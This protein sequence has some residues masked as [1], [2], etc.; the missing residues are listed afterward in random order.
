MRIALIS[1]LH[2]S[3]DAP[4]VLRGTLSL[5]GRSVALRQ[6]EFAIALGCERILCL[7]P[8]D[9]NECSR[10]AKSV[11]ER[12]AKLRIMSEAHQIVGHVHADDELLVLADGLLPEALEPFDC[13]DEGAGVLTL[14]ADKGIPA[15]FERIDGSKAW[16]GAMM[17]PGHLAERLME[18]P[19]DVDPQPALLR[20]G[21]QAQIREQALSNE[22]LSEGRWL[23]LK[24]Q[25]DV[26]VLEPLWLSRMVP[27]SQSFSPVRYSASLLLRHFGAQLSEHRDAI[28][29]L[30]GGV[31]AIFGLAI[32]ASWF[33]FATAAFAML[34][35]V[36]L[37]IAL[38]EGLVAIRQ[39]GMGSS[40]A[41]EDALG[42]PIV[43]ALD[44]VLIAIMVQCLEGDWATR[45]FAPIMLI[46]LIFL[47]NHKRRPVW[48]ELLNDRAIIIV[49]LTIASFLSQVGA[50]IMLLAMGLLLFCVWR[51]WEE[52]R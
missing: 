31:C 39:D 27:V 28:L 5:G 10:L 41:K 47:S 9:Q 45:L 40:L 42:S 6:L 15:G 1:L 12:G 44:A 34:V 37:M 33:G 13:L 43:L 46:G 22:L 25:A 36:P 19:A 8:G 51:A 20:I 18:L 52:K 14:H 17:L 38:R 7:A 29:Y 50:V 48:V 16:A 4:S 30:F 3:D 2:Q 21:L 24:R 32:I 23:M 35:P 11:K 49:L 26:E